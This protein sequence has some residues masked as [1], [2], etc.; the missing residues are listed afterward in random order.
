MR[1]ERVRQRAVE[2]AAAEEEAEEAIEQV[3]EVSR[4]PSRNLEC[5]QNER[6]SILLHLLAFSDVFVNNIE[7]IKHEDNL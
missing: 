5:E 7:S 3:E 2:A 4:L 1:Q 6:T